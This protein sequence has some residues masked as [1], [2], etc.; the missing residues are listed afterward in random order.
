MLELCCYFKTKQVFIF[1]W[2]F[3]SEHR[4]CSHIV[5]RTVTRWQIGIFGIISSFDFTHE[6][7]ISF[8]ALWA[9][10]KFGN[11]SA[12]QSPVLAALS[13]DLYQYFSTIVIKIDT[14]EF[15][16][17]ICSQSTI[18][19][20]FFFQISWTCSSHKNQSVSLH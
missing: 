10:M 1:I 6:I 18:P 17:H 14:D 11:F 9:L 13:L 5:K 2:V 16:G 12:W 15:F 7:W 3:L 4:T 8:P 20:V 19:S